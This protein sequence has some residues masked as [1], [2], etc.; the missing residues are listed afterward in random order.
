MGVANIVAA[1]VAI[2]VAAAQAQS[3]VGRRERQT[4]KPARAEDQRHDQSTSTPLPAAS[5]LI[6][7]A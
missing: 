1:L 2:G 6:S 4:H 7:P 5:T 3:G